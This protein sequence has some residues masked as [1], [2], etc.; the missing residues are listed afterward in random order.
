MFEI[1]DGRKYLYQWDSDIELLIANTSTDITEVHFL[2]PQGEVSLICEPYIDEGKALVKIPN[3][4]LTYGTDIT[5]FGVKKQGETCLTNCKHAI[6][7]VRR[8]RPADY[9][10]TET[11]VITF[12]A[13]AEKLEKDIEDRMSTVADEVREMVKDGE[14]GEDGKDGVDGFSPI[15]K[16]EETVDGA[17]ITVTDKNGT[18][19]AIVKNGE[20]A[21]IDEEELLKLAIKPTTDPATSLHIQDSAK[22]RVLDVSMSGKTEQNTTRGVQLF[23]LANSI[24]MYSQYGKVESVID[25]DNNTITVNNMHSIDR[26]AQMDLGLLEAGSYF[27]SFEV[28]GG[29][30]KAPNLLKGETVSDTTLISN[31]DI[32]KGIGFTLSES[33]RVWLGCNILTNTPLKLKNI[34]L[35]KVTV[36]TPHEEFTGGIPSPNTDFPQEIRHAGVYNEETGRYEIGCLVVNENH[37][38]ISS[39]I[40]GIYVSLATGQEISEKNQTSSDFVLLQTN[41]IYICFSG[42]VTYK[43]IC[44]YDSDK[45]FIS[46]D[47]VGSGHLKLRIPSGTRFIRYSFTTVNDINNANI[48]IETT[49]NNQYT[50]SYAPHASQPF[51]LTSDRPLTKWDNLVKVNGKWYWDYK[52][53]KLVVNGNAGWATYSIDTRSFYVYNILSETS[54]RREGCCNQLRVD[55]FGSNMTNCLWI[56]ISN[57]SIYIAYSDFY[58]ESLEDKG[59]A[60]LKA[61][62]NEHPLEIYTYKDESELVPL[63]DEEQTLL[64]NLETYY[65]VTNITNSEECMMQI[66][67]VADTKLYVDNKFKELQTSLAN[68][69][70]QLL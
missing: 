59:L 44:F 58:D 16:V 18:T 47:G 52:Q 20:S 1:L 7:V 29:Y 61:H 21:E 69:N 19:E 38:D 36:A 55:S 50:G 41:D 43:K 49:K 26:S 64:N 15:A 70:A 35:E 14:D 11:Q 32:T 65:G 23:D 30:S 63:P 66:Q 57:K 2:D 3:I 67:Y 42:D 13:L 28:V 51:T 9:V 31:I 6:R 5:I 22:Y 8:Q 33:A 17:K 34:Q 40:N 68:T 39:L 4:L 46:G 10:Y 37:A 24:G 54:N 25:L 12:Q 48:C 56:G 45:N 60:N 53:L 62:L 27:L